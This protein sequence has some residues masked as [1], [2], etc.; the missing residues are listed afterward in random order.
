MN[1]TL[2]TVATI[3]TFSISDFHQGS[4][5]APCNRF[6]V[7]VLYCRRYRQW[8]RTEKQPFSVSWGHEKSKSEVEF[9]AITELTLYVV[10]LVS[11]MVL[12]VFLGAQSRMSLNRE[13][14]KVRGSYRAVGTM[15][16]RSSKFRKKKWNWYFS[17]IVILSL[18]RS[19][20]LIYILKYILGVTTIFRLMPAR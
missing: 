12:N 3:L 11:K 5:W 2:F 15:M 1:E 19:W 17:I 20:K 13:D 18:L 10:Y 4:I 16:M 7:P 8:W 6:Y 14:W 9:T